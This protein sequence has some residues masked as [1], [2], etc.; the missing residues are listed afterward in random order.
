MTLT[1]DPPAP[2]IVD[3]GTRREFVVGGLSL[4]ALLLAGCGS[5]EDPAAPAEEPSAGDGFP[6]TIDHKYGSTDIPGMPERVVTVGLT[7]QDAVFALGV[8]PVASQAWYADRV[9]YPW[10]EEVAPG[11]R[12]KVMSSADGVDIET[13]AAQR[14]DLVVA[15]DS[16]LERKQY[17]LLSRLAP[18]VAAPRE[19][20]PSWQDQTLVV[21]RALGREAEAAELV[22]AAEKR[23]ADAAARHPEWTGASAI[24]ASQYVDGKLLVYPADSPMST[25]LTNL[26]FTIAPGLDEQFD[27]TYGVP[28]LSAE[29]FDLLDV[30]FVLWDGVRANLESAGL[31]DLATYKRLAV[32][33][34]GR[35]V[36]P[37]ER[38]ADALSFKNVLSWPWALERLEPQIAAAFGGG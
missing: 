9:M 37:E 18:T 31:F 13:V 5:D 7:D 19:E 22:A 3:D 12:T 6:V 38:V 10:A 34:E 29:R 36:F 17:D 1:L 25:F 2:E 32:V 21:G 24:L 35:Q 33:K 4:G 26:G 28:A 8:A 27:D 11:A 23:F 15:I 30:D 20:T 16:D 14:P